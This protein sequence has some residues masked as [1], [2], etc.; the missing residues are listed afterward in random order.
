M[1]E[2]VAMKD[3]LGAALAGAMVIVFGGAY[4][5]LFAYSKT[6]NIPRLMTAAYVSYFFLFVST[7]MLTL[8]LNLEGYW[9]IVVAVM[10]VGYLLAPHAIWH[11]CVGTHQEADAGD[12]AITRT[13]SSN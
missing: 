7:L 8:F 12:S 6:Q 10:V 9:R 3:L 13:T 11:L 1:I 2:P 4:A 5:L